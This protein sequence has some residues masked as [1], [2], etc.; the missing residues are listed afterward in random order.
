MDENLGVGMAALACPLACDLRLEVHAASLM[1]ECRQR[2]F[3]QLAVRCRRDGEGSCLFAGLDCVCA[4]LGDL[5]EI[6]D[7]ADLA[8]PRRSCGS[9]RGAFPDLLV[10]AGFVDLYLLAIVGLLESE[11]LFLIW[12]EADL[13]D[14][15]AFS[16]GWRAA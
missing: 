1:V 9:E 14:S 16:V 10:C 11:S 12:V 5:A 13:V 6:E 8:G 2:C 4:G 7:S 15:D 3:R